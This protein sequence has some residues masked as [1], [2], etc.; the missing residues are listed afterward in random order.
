MKTISVSELKTNLS[1]EIRKVEK[2]SS[3]LITDHDH[4][5]A[6]LTT[7][8]KNEIEWIQLAIKPMRTFKLNHNVSVKTDPLEILQEERSR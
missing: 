4:P 8:R 6:I 7:V 2:G 3:I 1:R 5:V